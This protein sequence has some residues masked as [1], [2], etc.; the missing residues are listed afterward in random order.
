MFHCLVVY[1][2]VCTLGMLQEEM[3]LTQ[4]FLF[5]IIWIHSTFINPLSYL[6][7][8]IPFVNKRLLPVLDCQCKLSSIVCHPHTPS[9]VPVCQWIPPP[10]LSLHQCRQLKFKIVTAG[11][12]I[13]TLKIMTNLYCTFVNSQQSMW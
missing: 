9:L 10:V 12:G 13:F 2:S 5:W 1:S 8:C 6:Q 4:C 3:S 7:R 11:E